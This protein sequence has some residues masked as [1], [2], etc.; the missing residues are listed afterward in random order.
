MSLETTE[1]SKSVVDSGVFAA[2]KLANYFGSIAAKLYVQEPVIAFYFRKA[3]GAGVSKEIDNLVASGLVEPER[4]GEVR[5]NFA[6]S[7]DNITKDYN[8]VA[9]LFNGIRHYWTFGPEDE[10]SKKKTVEYIEKNCNGML[11]PYYLRTS[12]NLLLSEM[13]RRDSIVAKLVGDL[14]MP[15]QMTVDD[16]ISLKVD[17][18]SMRNAVKV[19][20]KDADDYV[21]TRKEFELSDMKFYMVTENLSE[22]NIEDIWKKMGK[23]VT[24]RALFA[25]MLSRFDRDD[26]IIDAMNRAYVGAI[27]EKIA[28]ADTK[29]VWV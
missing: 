13:R 7:I 8:G 28:V 5:E 11:A 26:K 9:R 14:K 2:N 4:V 23:E 16:V 18:E 24:Q 21:T 6:K 29:E 12:Y 15:D 10:S 20:Y 3:A 1:S 25:S 22:K 17:E 27:T 19:G